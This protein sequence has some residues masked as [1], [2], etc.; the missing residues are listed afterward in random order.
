MSGT[1]V[2]IARDSLHPR[3]YHGDDTYG[4]YSC[5]K[6]HDVPGHYRWLFDTEAA[7]DK[8]IADHPQHDAKFSALPPAPLAVDPASQ[9][10]PTYYHFCGSDGYQDHPL[11]PDA[12]LKM[13]LD[14]K[15]Q[16][17]GEAKLDDYVVE[18]APGVFGLSFELGGHD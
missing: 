3:T 9:G 6:A 16:S 4:S 8:F 15:A 18:W 10:H 1:W 11:D 17:A 7:R 14:G 13:R 5:V 2:A 12:D